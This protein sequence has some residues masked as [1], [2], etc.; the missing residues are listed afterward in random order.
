MCAISASE[1]L[2]GGKDCGTCRLSE[3]SLYCLLLFQLAEE[4]QDCNRG[5][6]TVDA[7]TLIQHVAVVAFLMHGLVLHPEFDVSFN[8]RVLNGIASSSVFS[9]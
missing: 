2:I 6:Q 1:F 7:R 4:M 9:L 3:S 8:G 5:K